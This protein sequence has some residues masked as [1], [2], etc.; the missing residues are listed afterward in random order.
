MLPLA[1]RKLAGKRIGTGTKRLI[2]SDLKEAEKVIMKDL[3]IGI[4]GII[5]R[6]LKKAVS[7]KKKPA[8]RKKAGRPRGS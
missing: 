6:T 4:K 3:S 7:G 2:R 5:K 1:G 8:T